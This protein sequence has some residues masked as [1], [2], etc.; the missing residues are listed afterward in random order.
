MYFSLFFFLFD[1]MLTESFQYNGNFV[2]SFFFSFFN[3]ELLNMCDMCQSMWEGGVSERIWWV[4]SLYLI[5]WIPG[6]KL[7]FS[8]L[9]GKHFFFT[10]GPSHWP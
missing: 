6:T 2:I 5:L 3:S 7:K 1:F 9:H 10:T 8:G 4:G